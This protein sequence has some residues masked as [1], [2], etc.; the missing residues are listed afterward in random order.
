MIHSALYFL[1]HTFIH[2]Y[3]SLRSARR[4]SSVLDLVPLS[5]QNLLVAASFALTMLLL[6]EVA[7]IFYRMQLSRD[8]EAISKNMK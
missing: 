4:L 8:H 1:L 2:F 7:K 3:T 5:P 6:N